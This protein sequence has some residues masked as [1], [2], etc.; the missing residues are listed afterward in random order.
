MD[1]YAKNHGDQL[2]PGHYTRFREIDQILNLQN[3]R[4]DRYELISQLKKWGWYIREPMFDALLETLKRPVQET[5]DYVFTHLP[6]P[7]AAQ[8]DELTAAMVTLMNNKGKDARAQQHEFNLA[9]EIA[10]KS[11]ATW[12]MVFNTL[13]VR[14]GAYNAVFS[15]DSREFKNYIRNFA[16]EITQAES[17]IR[18]LAGTAWRSRDNENHSY[19]AC[20]E[21]GSTGG[22]LHIHCLHFFRTLPDRWHDP[23]RGRQRPHL[24]EISAIKG[25]WQHGHSSPIAVR[26]SPKDAYGLSGW[27]WPYDLK[28]NNSLRIG[29]PLKLGSYM[30]KYINKGYAS[31]KRSKLLWRVRKTQQLGSHV[32]AE[33]VSQLTPPALIL[34]ATD[35]TIRLKL[36]NR[37]IPPQLLRQTALKRYQNLASTTPSKN[38][39]TLRAL[40]ENVSPRPSLLHSLRGS[41]TQ[42]PLNNLRNTITSLTNECSLAD[43]SK[44]R[45]EI[46]KARKEIDDKYYRRS[47]SGY[48]TTATTDFINAKDTAFTQAYRTQAQMRSHPQSAS[49]RKPSALPGQSN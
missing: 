22:R 43:T 33:L 5:M 42:T 44:L 34:L 18:N 4:L 45:D 9:S 47:F 27:R 14:N 8:H 46:A 21:E 23:N 40:A 36:N 15:R 13:T 30:S 7:K 3:S 6:T 49:A 17:G 11:T 26:Y 37:T 2:S 1:Y 24:R 31:C 10:Y 41:T 32:M 20:V 48:G 19:F 35:E 39:R 29:S 25:L 16:R 28:T 12:Y 38:I